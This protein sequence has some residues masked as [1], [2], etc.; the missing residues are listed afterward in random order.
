L[1]VNPN[2]A[3]AQRSLEQVQAAKAAAAPKN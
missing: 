2:Y 3:P 1:K